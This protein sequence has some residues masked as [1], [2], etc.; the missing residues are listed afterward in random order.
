MAIGAKLAVEQFAGGDL[1]GLNELSRLE[2]SNVHH[3]VFL[4]EKG[5]TYKPYNDQIAVLYFS[6]L[7]PHLV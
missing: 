1:E 4:R 3:S 7:R 6:V 5:E 2:V